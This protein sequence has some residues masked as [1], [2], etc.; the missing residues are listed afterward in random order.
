[1][2]KYVRLEKAVGE[3][4]LSALE[5]YRTEH[6]ELL[7]VPLTYAG[8]LDPMAS[9]TLLILCGDECKVRDIY[10]ALDKEYEFE[11][12][13]GYSTDTGDTLGMPKRAAKTERYSLNKLSQIAAKLRGVHTV[14]YPAFSSKTV[15]GKP[16]F[17]YAL[18]NKLHTIAIPTVEMRIYKLRCESVRTITG[19]T[20]LERILSKIVLLKSNDFRAEAIGLAWSDLLKNDN[21][22]YAIAKFRAVVGSGSYIR[23]LAPMI[24]K[25]AGT[26]GIAYSIHRR[27]IGRY[28]PIVGRFGWW[29][30]R[31]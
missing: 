13:F 18:S 1:M 30:K 19:S 20:L 28:M 31:Y 11:V 12:L 15:A 6:P 5:A 27:A 17:E 2:Q 25:L 7:N 22:Q 26:D 8:R 16:L 14:P 23:T 29:R 21:T 3:T 4:P 24:A 10:N 9:G